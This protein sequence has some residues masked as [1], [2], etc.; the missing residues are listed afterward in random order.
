MSTGTSRPLSSSSPRTGLGCSRLA[1]G[2]G[3]CLLGLI[4]CPYLTKTQLVRLST[5]SFVPESRCCYAAVLCFAVLCHAVP[6]HATPHHAKTWLPLFVAAG[7]ALAPP[8]PP[9]FASTPSSMTSS[10][11]YG[12]HI[13]SAL[14]SQGMEQVVMVP[15]AVVFMALCVQNYQP[16]GMAFYVCPQQHC[17]QSTNTHRPSYTLLLNLEKQ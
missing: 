6:C 8:S 3:K 11:L 1:T 17:S 14:H 7:S 9:P 16:I 4:S 13:G 12:F 5:P 15:Q 10:Y 2:S